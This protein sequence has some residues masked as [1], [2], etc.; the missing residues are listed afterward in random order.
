MKNISFETVNEFDLSI[1]HNVIHRKNHTFEID[2]HVHDKCE[3]Y[4][5][6]SG[7]ISFMVENKIYPVKRGDA[8]LTRPHE[9]HH[10]IYHSDAPHEYYWILFSAQGNETIL[11]P[12]F[13]RPFGEANLI[14]FNGNDGERLIQLCETFYKKEIQAIERQ[15]LFWEMMELLNKGNKVNHSETQIHKSEISEALNYIESRLIDAIRITE[16]ARISNV[17]VNTLE[18]RFYEELNMTP[19]EYI[20]KKRLNLAANFLR[21]GYNVQQA[22]MESGFNDISYFIKLFKKS[23]GMTPFQYRKCYRDKK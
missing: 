16:L 4:V 14:T 19:M 23:Y 1:V 8:I 6:L 5:N 3:I 21:H 9:Y 12:F 18:R 20:K 11:K 17:S 15:L 2:S 22:G 13:K 7:D 10:C